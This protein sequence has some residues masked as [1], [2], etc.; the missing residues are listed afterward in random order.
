MLTESK[1][2]TTIEGPG[3]GN[4]KEHGNYYSPGN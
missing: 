4:E 3:L 2:E 1:M